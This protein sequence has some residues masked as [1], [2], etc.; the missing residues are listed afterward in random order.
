MGEQPPIRRDRYCHPLRGAVGP[1]PVPSMSQGLVPCL[2]V[3]VN[4][5]TSGVRG[6]TP[7]MWVV[8]TIRILHYVVFPVTGGRG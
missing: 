2:W 3:R 5:V 4:Q 7:A 8:H 1:L 6:C